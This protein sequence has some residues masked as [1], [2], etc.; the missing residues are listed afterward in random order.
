MP[1][2]RFKEVIMHGIK[3]G[4]SDIHIV[5]GQP[6]I[7]RK[8]GAI[9]YE[10]AIVWSHQ[11]VDNLV[12]SLLTGRQLQ[13]L[14]QR[15]SVDCAVTTNGVRIRMNIF[16]TTRGLSLAIRLLP[17]VIPEIDS[18]NLHPSLRQ[19]KD[20][21]SGLVLVCGSTG[22]GKSTTLAAIL[23]EINRTRPAHIVTL[24]DPIEYRFLPKKA[25]IEQREVGVHVPSFKQ[26]LLDVLREAPDII[27]VG[28]LRE[29]DTIRLALTAAESGH[30]VFASLHATDSEDAVY[31]INNAV[32]GESQDIIRYQFA[33]ALSW[34]IVQQ[35]TFIEKAGFRI[36]VLSVLRDSIP[37][38]NII[39]ENK[40]I[41]LETAM[42]TGRA[43]GMFTMDRYLNE[44]IN[45]ITSF[46]RPYKSAWNPEA[47]VPD[48]D[49]KSPLID[50]DAIQDIVY[51]AAVEAPPRDAK[52]KSAASDTHDTQYVI[53]EAPN[54]EDL[55]SQINTSK[56]Q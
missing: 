11:E 3:Q 19:I 2:E 10:R 1:T 32:A 52:N 30:L 17:E 7:L 14:R 51:T 45:T 39:R 13:T 8:D 12:K 36:P 33:S 47:K 43:E 26:G 31:R 20:L 50:P 25:F 21:K 27:L 15:W 56:E 29:P 55:L 48:T 24:E 40:L 18:L 44:F 38:K 41:Q 5:G 34:L 46:A 6:L 49:Y 37:V 28:E 35:L 9:H 42:H 53:D 54:L 23:E 22:S 4:I 16:H